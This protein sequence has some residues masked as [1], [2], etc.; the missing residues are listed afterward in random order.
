MLIF[1]SL[2]RIMESPCVEGLLQA[3][4]SI[5]IQEDSLHYVTSCL[6]ELAKQEGAM[7]HM[8]KWM[9]E[10]LTKRLVRLAGQR[11][12][13]EPSFHAASIIQHMID[14]EKMM[15]LLKCHIREI[16]AYLRNF[17][18]HQEVRFQQLAISTFCRLQAGMSS[19]PGSSLGALPAPISSKG[20]SLSQAV[21][22]T[23]ELTASRRNPR[24]AATLTVLSA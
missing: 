10:P 22:C 9:N 4:L 6:A 3:M 23:P 24:A 7:L 20:K 13:S 8:V 16:Q 11:E 5:D 21:T 1:F 12:H 18:T 14:H 2:Q 19:P 17:L 15:L